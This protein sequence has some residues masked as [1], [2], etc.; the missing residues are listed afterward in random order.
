MLV[1]D[2]FIY[3]WTSCLGECNVGI[4]NLF[5][6]YILSKVVLAGFYY[7]KFLDNENILS[8]HSHH[9]ERYSKSQVNTHLYNMLSS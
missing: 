5:Q 2:T 6:E 4:K 3:F 1:S 7:L 8:I 9:T